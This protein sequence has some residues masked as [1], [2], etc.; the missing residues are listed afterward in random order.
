[1]NEVRGKIGQSASERAVVEQMESIKN[2][3]RKKIV[4]KRKNV[5][6]NII[7]NNERKFNKFWEKENDK[8]KNK[9]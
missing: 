6:Y 3:K 2:T 7:I 5:I 4:D 9:H 1:M 8:S